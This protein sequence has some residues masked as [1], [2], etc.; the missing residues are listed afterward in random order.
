[1]DRKESRKL[2]FIKKK[3]LEQME[4]RRRYYEKQ[5]KFKKSIKNLQ[6]ILSSNK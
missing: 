1:M 3:Q 4:K 5:R 2:F 6:Q